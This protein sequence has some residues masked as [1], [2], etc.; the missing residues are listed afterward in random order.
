MNRMERPRNT[1]LM[2]VHEVAER[3]RVKVSWVYAH[4]DDLGAFRLGKYLRF[5]WPRVLNHLASGPVRTPFDEMALSD[6]QPAS[7]PRQRAGNQRH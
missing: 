3:L 4:S 2:T 6:D 7:E 5:S 1:Q